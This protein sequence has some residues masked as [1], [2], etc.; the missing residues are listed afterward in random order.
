M[1]FYART[2]RHAAP[3]FLDS[4]EALVNPVVGWESQRGVLAC[5]DLPRRFMPA[6]KYFECQKDAE[7]CLLL[8]HQAM[9]KKFRS[10]QMR[11]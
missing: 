11:G 9:L 10:V 3:Y 4:T 6:E 7:N 5:V 8:R 1:G 2:H